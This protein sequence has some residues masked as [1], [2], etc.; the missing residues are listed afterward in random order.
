M[1]DQARNPLESLLRRIAAAAPD[2]WYPRRFAKEKDFPERRL[3]FLLEHLRLDGLLEKG[4]TTAESGE[5]VRL[6]P[7]GEKL[8]QDPDGLRRLRE[9]EPVTPGDRGGAI[10]GIFRRDTSALITRL[11]IFFNLFVFGVGL[12]WANQQR[13]A[14]EFLKAPFS[15][16]T[17][18]VLSVLHRTGSVGAVDLLRGQWWRLITSCFVHIGLLHIALNMFTLNSLGRNSEPMWGRWRYLVIYLLSGFAGSCLAMAFRPGA[19]LAG[20]SGAICGVFGAEI[21]WL[22]LNGRY[23]PRGTARRWLTGQLLSLVLLAGI[24]SIP[25]V[26]ALGHIGG[27]GA[28][29][30]AAL[31]LN[32]Q[33]F[34]PAGWRWLALVPTAALVIAGFETVRQGQIRNSSWHDIEVRYFLDDVAHRVGNGLSE[35]HAAL[36]QANRK[37]PDE[38]E[39]TLTALRKAKRDLGELDR[40]LAGL[41]THHNEELEEI[42]DSRRERIAK[43]LPVL[44]STEEEV[45]QRRAAAVRE[46]ERQ[47]RRNAEEEKEDKDF[48]TRFV[49]RIDK[50]AAKAEKTIKEQDELL[51][52]KPPR[53][54][55]D[56]ERV[57]V[58]ARADRTALQ[59]ILAD[60]PKA[61]TFKS[62]DAAAAR[63]LAEDYLTLIDQLLSRADAILTA[64]S[65]P[66]A[67]DSKKRKL[68]IARWLSKQDAWKDV[69]D[70]K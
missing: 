68:L 19:M 36:Q 56:V 55:K 17:V 62:E 59:E 5:G 24:S 30:L 39:A 7:A 8:L 3:E 4:D 33:R 45:E 10:R 31:F 2:S 53:D 34:G 41:D 22:L 18:I 13:A 49:I 66:T 12:Y 46:Q 11:L 52:A 37:R 15:D 43:M 48:A 14:G 9:G 58:A 69:A 16:V 21:V 26:S 63:N 28:G 67:D 1:T 61:G 64:D 65:V 57:S 42:R 51:A 29:A 27:L 23:L 60:L 35:A 70:R 54:R 25:G 32:W 50:A 38:F 40:E 47:A 44:D 20:A 6:S